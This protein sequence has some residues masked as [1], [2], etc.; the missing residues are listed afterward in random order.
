MDNHALTTLLIINHNKHDNV[1]HFDTLTLWQ[2]L[3]TIHISH[4][5]RQTYTSVISD[6]K[7]TQY[8]GCNH[9]FILRGVLSRP[10][11][12][13]PFPVFPSLR[14]SPANPA[15][16]F[17]GTLL[18]SQQDQL[19]TAATRHVPW[20]P[21]AATRHVP[22]AG[23]PATRHVPWAGAPAANAFLESTANVVLFLLNEI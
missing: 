9:R 8:Q 5:R 18:A 11:H 23:A 1:W 19:T 15:K 10:F 17:R 16:G 4:I 21:A 6:V 3:M 14:S 20:A 13:F 7:H 12:I 22:W 2:R